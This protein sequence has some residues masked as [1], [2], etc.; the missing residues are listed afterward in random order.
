MSASV[1]ELERQAEREREEIAAT[2]D[3]LRNRMSPGHMLDE[4]LGFT[5]QS[6]AG[7]GFENLVAQVRDNPM[8]AALIGTGVAWMMAGPAVRAKVGSDGTASDPAERRYPVGA[9]GLYGGPGAYGSGVGASAQEGAG[10]S[11]T[12]DAESKLHG[13]ASEVGS[14]ARS[15]RD[16]ADRA[17]HQAADAGHRATDKA[18][19]LGRE[20]RDT[21][22]SMASDASATA[23]RAGEK[24]AGAAQGAWHDAE[25]A[26]S[27]AGQ[28]AADAGRYAADRAAEAGRYASDEAAAAGRYLRQTFGD[29]LEREPL[30]I[31]ALGLAVGAAIG[32]MLPSTRFE[33]EHFGAERDRLKKEAE[34][35]LKEG[36]HDAEDVASS[37]F[38]AAK[39]KSKQEG[40]VPGDEPVADKVGKV[41]G[42]AAD[43]AETSAKRKMG[44]AD[45]SKKA[46]PSAGTAGASSSGGTTTTPGTR[47]P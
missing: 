35:R 10:S 7:K 26:A 32:A 36:V 42:A 45:T 34:D 5:K 18:S 29:I 9:E 19:E 43:A 33:D 27:R 38:G 2:A 4:A 39:A 20:A 8:A 40:L 3:R 14:A 22:S 30:V 12:R 31:G 25:D 24:A 11:L 23:R 47:K 21:A 13:A 16:A 17:G 28:S 41:A 15:A 1:S 44:T 46:S 37:A 6:D